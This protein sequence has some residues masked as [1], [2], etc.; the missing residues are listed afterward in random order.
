MIYFYR[1]NYNKVYTVSQF[2]NRYM[3]ANAH[4]SGNWFW[5]RTTRNKEYLAFKDIYPDK[6]TDCSNTHVHL[7][8]NDATKKSRVNLFLVTITEYSIL[9]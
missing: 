7:P 3:S 4:T 5:S 2:I 9:E 6:E 8:V 1:L